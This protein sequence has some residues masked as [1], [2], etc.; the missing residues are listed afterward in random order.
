MAHKYPFYIKGRT[1]MWLHYKV[2]HQARNFCMLSHL[3]LVFFS[4]WEFTE[5]TFYLVFCDSMPKGLPNKATCPYESDL[6]QITTAIELLS[7]FIVKI[8][9]WTAFGPCIC[10][11][12]SKEPV[13]CLRHCLTSAWQLRR[14]Q[15]LTWKFYSVQGKHLRQD[16]LVQFLGNALCSLQ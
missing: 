4:L 1:H 6:S 11:S 16:K 2:S 7:Q 10:V 15:K 8:S 14:T 12:C 3:I 5:V 13:S 9:D